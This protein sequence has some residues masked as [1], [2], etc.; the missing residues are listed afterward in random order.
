MDISFSVL[1]VHLALEHVSLPVL[2]QDAFSCDFRLFRNPV[3][4]IVGFPSGTM[5]QMLE[6]SDAT[7]L[8]NCFFSDSNVPL[9]C[10]P[11]KP[12]EN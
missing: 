10:M 9:E 5:E 3:R 11:P 8:H 12:K 2:A 1:V 7:H 4:L 6:N